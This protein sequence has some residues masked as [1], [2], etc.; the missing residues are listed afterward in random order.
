MGMNFRWVMNHI[1]VLIVTGLLTIIAL[2]SGCGKKEKPPAADISITPELPEGKNRLPKIQE[3]T[4]AELPE[5][6]QAVIGVAIVPH[7]LTTIPEVRLNSKPGQEVMFEAKVMGSKD[8][9]AEN[10]ASFMVGDENTVASCDLLGVDERCQTPWDVHHEDAEA[11]RNGTAVI[12][13]VNDDG[14]V[15]KT[16]LRGAA[17]I[18]ELSRL[19]ITGTVAPESTEDSLVINAKAIQILN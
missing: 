16:G 11:V 4:E 18:K 7:S 8:P 17:G 19:R 3:I 13:I 15:L 12:Q 6:I 2:G 5:A 10:R 1:T 14:R 9:F